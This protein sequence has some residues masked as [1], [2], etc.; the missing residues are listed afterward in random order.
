MNYSLYKI[1]LDTH[2]TTVQTVLNI[3]RNDTGRKIIIGL[4]SGG[5]AYPITSE[6]IAVFRAKKPDGTVLYNHCA[7]EDNLITYEL[8]SQTSAS[9]GLVDCEVTLYG[10]SDFRSVFGESAPEWKQNTYFSLVDGVYDITIEKPGDWE[11]NWHNYYENA[12]QITSPRFCILVD[13]AV[14][15]DD[16]IE[17][18]N[19]F[20]ELLS[21]L[22]RLAGI[23]LHENTRERNEAERKAAELERIR[24]ELLRVENENKRVSDEAIRSNKEDERI[25]NENVRISNENKRIEAEKKRMSVFIRYSEYPDGSNMTV[26]HSPTQDFIGILSS[27]EESDDPADYTWYY[28]PSN[29]YDV[30]IHII[31]NS[32]ENELI[33]TERTDLM[34]YA[35]ETGINGWKIEEENISGY[36]KINLNAIRFNGTEKDLTYSDIVKTTEKIEED[37]SEDGYGKLVKFMKSAGNYVTTKEW[38]KNYVR[39]HSGSGNVMTLDIYETGHEGYTRSVTVVKDTLI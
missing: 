15:T 9:E 16:E 27:K 1:Y 13:E 19:E 30:I 29:L 28:F 38:V 32:R 6:C 14:Q 20:T 21:A 18:R 2:K 17:S 31:N 37:Y 34:N 33:D 11:T 5:K 7:I 10:N 36:G 26:T 24:N 3:K 39:E 35:A 22:A 25:S 23:E 12:M 4:T 8:T